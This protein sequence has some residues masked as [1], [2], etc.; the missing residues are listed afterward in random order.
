MLLFMNSVQNMR[1][2]NILFLFGIVQRSSKA[3]RLHG[4]TEVGVDVKEA[5]VLSDDLLPEK[6]L[7]LNYKYLTRHYRPYFFKSEVCQFAMF[8]AFGL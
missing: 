3:R 2:S 4:A 8:L 7:L 5:G 6:F 1:D